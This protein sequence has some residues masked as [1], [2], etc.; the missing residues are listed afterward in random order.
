MGR[1]QQEP[2][3]PETTPRSEDNGPRKLPLKRI[4]YSVF[5]GTLS[6]SVWDK[7]I[8]AQGGERTLY[9]VS[10]QRSYEEN[11]QR[12][13][14]SYLR[15]SDIPVAVIAME[16]AYREIN[17]LRQPVQ[18]PLSVGPEDIPF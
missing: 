8:Q 3:A 16:D 2:A 5:S 18:P 11:G 14:T 7:T 13:W 15:D 4:Y 6:V 12:K 10:V 1:K 9:S 17:R